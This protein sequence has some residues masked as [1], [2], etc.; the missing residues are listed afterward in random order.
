MD[1]L[2]VEIVWLF[3]SHQLLQTVGRQAMVESS[4]RSSIWF[5]CPLSSSNKCLPSTSEETIKL[6]LKL[7]P[8]HEHHRP[9]VLEESYENR[10]D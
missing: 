4:Q 9:T 2:R 3:L 6:P 5:G 8:T 10:E 7:P 1:A